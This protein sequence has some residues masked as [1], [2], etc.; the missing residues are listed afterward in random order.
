M[1]IGDLLKGLDKDPRLL[2]KLQRSMDKAH[3]VDK[4]DIANASPL[5]CPACAALKQT[6]GTLYIHKSDK[7]L[8]TCRKCKLTF[9][10]TCETLPTEEL[11]YNIRQI[12]K[13][14]LEAARFW[15][16]RLTND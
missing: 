3:F 15:T 16:E 7:S 10:V 4:Y 9:R 2:E 11:M 8:F 14:D 6:P 12:K 5:K 13:G 1:D